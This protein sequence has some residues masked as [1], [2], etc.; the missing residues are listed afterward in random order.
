MTKFISKAYRDFSDLDCLAFTFFQ[1]YLS[2]HPPPTLSGYDVTNSNQ[3][4]KLGSGFFSN[5]DTAGL[6]QM[7]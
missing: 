6:D 5:Q 3:V 4:R 2:W 1:H 7:D